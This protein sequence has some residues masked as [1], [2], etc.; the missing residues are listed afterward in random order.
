MTSTFVNKYSTALAKKWFTPRNAEFMYP[1]KPWK[2]ISV[3][4]ISCIQHFLVVKHDQRN[5]D[6]IIILISSPF[7]LSLHSLVLSLS[8]SLSFFLSYSISHYFIPFLFSLK[9]TS[10]LFSF[11]LSFCFLK[12][13][14]SLSHKT[15]SL[16]SYLSRA[17]LI[18][19]MEYI[20]LTMDIKKIYACIN[21]QYP[22]FPNIFLNSISVCDFFGWTFLLNF[23][24]INFN[25][26]FYCQL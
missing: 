10:S 22:S 3:S 26:S 24:L 17:V 6:S 9:H 11:S 13:T 20:Q 8:L 2:T 21:V 4:A 15:H 12:Q 1:E 18:A 5:I 25:F 23:L 16:S 14:F 19:L 7:A